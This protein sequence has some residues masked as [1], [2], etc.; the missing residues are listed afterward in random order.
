MAPS[1]SP[2]PDV[3]DTPEASTDYSDMPGLVYFHKCC[4]CAIMSA[5]CIWSYN[6]KGQ[7]RPRCD[8]CTRGR[9]L[10][11]PCPPE[12]LVEY[13]AACQSTSPPAHRAPTKGDGVRWDFSQ[14]LKHHTHEANQAAKKAA[15]EASAATA[16]AAAEVNSSVADTF[17]E[18][19]ASVKSTGTRSRVSD[20]RSAPDIST[21][22]TVMVCIPSA[23][24]VPPRI[25]GSFLIPSRGGAA[26]T[27]R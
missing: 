23:P 27:R 13:A 2:S 16:G 15:T 8:R 5:D 10:C 7:T 25:R 1:P 6:A 21:R 17:V 24:V 3:V 26:P 19:S 22:Q 20:S 18:G 4:C 9:R 14:A 11:K 12:L